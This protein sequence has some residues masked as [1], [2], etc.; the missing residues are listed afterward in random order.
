[1][2]GTD[3]S[4]WLVCFVAAGSASGCSL[5]DQVGG[6]ELSFDLPDARFKIDTGNSRWWPN[7]PRGV[8]QVICRGPA[9]LVA[10]CCQPSAVIDPPVDC[11]EYPLSCD[12][13]SMCAL[14]FDYDDVAEID[15]GTGVL[16]LHDQRRWV[17]A[18]ATVDQI[19]IAVSRTDTKAAPLPLFAV[20]L[21][22]APYG[23]V[24][25]RTSGAMFLADIP[26]K[27][28]T[29]LVDLDPSA[30]LA[31]S[32]FLTDFNT[33]FNLILSSRVVVESGPAPTG[34]MTIDVYGGRVYASF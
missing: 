22:V 14:A 26:W 6:G 32:T 16:A 20:S 9:A 13:N 12:D 33:P 18:Q 1:M 19:K 28:D 11:Q 3:G 24:S 15:L 8:P 21:Y 29:S 4:L 7:P 30:R 17:F 25:A 27:M 2:R 34:T 10:D 5:F 23:V 31:L